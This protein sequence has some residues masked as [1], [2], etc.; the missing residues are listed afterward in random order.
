LP[1]ASG[2]TFDSYLNQH[3]DECLLGTR[4]DLLQEIAEWA[5]SLD[6]KCIYWL[7]GMAGTGK[8]TISRTLSKSL[9]RDG[10]LGATFF[11]RRGEGDC[12]NAS[13]LFSTI[14]RQLVGR[15]PKLIPSVSKE[16]YNDPDIAS[17]SL[18]VQFDSLIFRPLLELR[19]S[20]SQIRTVVI[21]ID[22]LDECE[23]DNDIRTIIQLLPQLRESKTLRLRVFLTSRPELPI[24]LGFSKI[25]IHD[26]QSLTLHE[27]SET[28]TEYDIT[29]FLQNR[30]AQ[31]RENRG[32]PMDWPADDTIRTLVTMSVP[33]FI[34]A[35]TVC[36]YIEDPKWDPAKRLAELLEGQARYARKM[37]KTY[38]PILMQFLNNQDDDE[39]EQLLQQFRQIIGSI[40]LLAVPLSMNTLCMFLDISERVISKLLDSFLSVLNIPSDHDLPVRILHSSFRDF[41]FSSNSLFRVDEG[42]THKS[43]AIRCFT[44]MRGLLKKNICSLR[45]CGTPRTEISNETIH[46]NVPLSLQYSCRYWPHHLAQSADLVTGMGDVLSFLTQHFLHWLEVMSILGLTFECAGSINLLQSVTHVS[47]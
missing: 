36:R 44:T 28:S 14:A 47:P 42:L 27:I 9:Y 40:A 24:R 41:L 39:S 46:R 17:K 19:E 22:A 11:F 25:A 18:K 3:D 20:N 29:L 1:V 23:L 45:S 8:S 6:G 16:I 33:L 12:G 32:L 34:T 38:L 35:A 4:A 5:V 15:I 21:V 13:K 26:Y 7:N 43:I 2:A 10:L 31:L 30:F 37:D